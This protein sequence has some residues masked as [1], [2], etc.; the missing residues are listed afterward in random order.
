M[1][2]SATAH[3]ARIAHCVADP[4]ESGDASAV[5]QFSDGVLVVED[6]RVS[7]LGPANALLPTLGEDVALV[8]HG[9]ALIVPGLID[10]HV[11]YPQLDVMGAYG[12]Q[13]LD[14]LETYTYPAERR[15]ADAAFARAAAERFL[16]ALL[17]NGTTTALVFATVHPASV[18]AFFEAAQARRLRMAAGKVL[19]DRHCPTDLSDTAVTGYRYSRAIMEFWHGKDLLH[20]WLTTRFAT[21]C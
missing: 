13:L 5:E 1:T 9:D 14:W 8:E 10:C 3:R 4:G 7:A 6:G 19:M 16:D 2:A 17:A 20:F 18:E 15:F 11:H 21:A 12:L